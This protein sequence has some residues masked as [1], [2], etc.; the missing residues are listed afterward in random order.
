[1]SLKKYMPISIISI[2]TILLFTISKVYAASGYS[3]TLTTFNMSFSISPADSTYTSLTGTVQVACTSTGGNNTA[4]Y[5]L[6]LSTGLSG[7]YSAR[8]AF[9][10]SNTAAY[11]LYQDAPFTTILGNGTGGTATITNSYALNGNQTI[12][13]NHPIYGKVPVQPLAIP[14]LTYTDSITATLSY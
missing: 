7:S 14:G 10:G 5:T 6:T 12:T 1:M 9:N 4:S 3:C 8:K 11:N 13:T 2:F